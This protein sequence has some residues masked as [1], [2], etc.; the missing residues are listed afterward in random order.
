[1]VKN[2]HKFDFISLT[3]DKERLVF[4]QSLLKNKLKF[5]NLRLVGFAV[6]VRV[7]ASSVQCHQFHHVSGREQVLFMTCSIAESF[8]VSKL[9]SESTMYYRERW[10]SCRWRGWRG[11]PVPRGFFLSKYSSKVQKEPRAYFFG[12]RLLPNFSRKVF[13]T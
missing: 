8:L 7:A 4:L 13:S 12:V 3:F 6:K 1:M 5:F 10:G 9:L 2:I 11:L